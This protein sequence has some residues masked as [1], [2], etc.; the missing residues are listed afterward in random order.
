MTF[1]V[2]LQAICV[3]YAGSHGGGFIRY[4][5]IARSSGAFAEVFVE[6]PVQLPGNGFGTVNVNHTSF[7]FAV[8]PQEGVATVEGDPF[9]KV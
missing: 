1:P 4:H 2:T 8:F 3:R 6:I 7:T 9:S 5:A